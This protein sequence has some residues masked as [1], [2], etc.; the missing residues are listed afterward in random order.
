[1]S[2]KELTGVRLSSCASCLRKGFYEGSG[3]E[4]APLSDSAER[5]FKIRTAQNDGI[6]AMHAAEMRDAGD[7]VELEAEIPWGPRGCWTGHADLVNHTRRLVREYTG[8]AGCNLDTRK[9]RQ[10]A[11]YAHHFGYTAEVVVFDPSTGEMQVYPVNVE[12]F[13]WEMENIELEITDALALDEPPERVCKT[14]YDGPAMFCQFVGTCF[15]GWAWPQT[16]VVDDPDTIALAEELAA[17][18][19]QAK[20]GAEAEKRVKELKGLLAGLV[21][22]GV[23]VQVGSVKVRI[24]DVAASETLPLGDFKKAGYALPD[25]VA[26]FVKPKASHSRTTVTRVQS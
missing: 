11:W 25:E 14:P 23:D 7:E 19:E 2:T 10:V 12:A 4:K 5:L 3:A 16:R 8:T 22:H 9:V 13:G 20:K 1:M 24:S 18:Q 17:V 26:A 6:V 15:S 21:E